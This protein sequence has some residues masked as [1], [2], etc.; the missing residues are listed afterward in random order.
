MA[1]KTQQ[2]EEKGSQENLIKSEN[3]DV[4]FEKLKLIVE[5]M[6]TGGLTLDESL[7]LFEEGVGLSRT[8]FDVLNVAEGRVEELLSNMERAPFSRGE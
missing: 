2:Q 4:T 3:F 5:K 6:E 7:S 1:R 8:L